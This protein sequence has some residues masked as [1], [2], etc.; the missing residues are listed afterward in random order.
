[1]TNEEVIRELAQ[2]IY[3]IKNDAVNDIEAGSDEDIAF[4]S[5]TRRYANMWIEEFELEAEW[6]M[7]REND[8]VLG[9][10]TEVSNRTIPI[11]DATVRTVVTSPYRSLTISQD[12][13]TISTFIVVKPDQIGDPSNPDTRDRATVIGRNIKL[14]RDLTEQELGGTVT[15]DVIHYFPKISSDYTD[16]SVLS[17]IDPILL[18]KLGIA[19]TSTLPN[20]IQGQLS[21]SYVQKYNDLLSK[22]VALNNATADTD[23]AL[24]ED[25]SFISGVY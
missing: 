25:F 3:L 8:Y 19:K 4:L 6:R 5:E 18:M 11:T 13:T 9:T 24:T 17:L 10:I 2:D 15:A 22:A 7:V 12:G 16:I 1:M 20:V 23:D 21:P 14:S